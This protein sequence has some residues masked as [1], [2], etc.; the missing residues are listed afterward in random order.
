M[1][2]A[3]KVTIADDQGVVEEQ[4]TID[5]DDY[6]LEST[7]HRESLGSTFVHHIVNIRTRQALRFAS[8]A[9]L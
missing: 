4:F 5:P 8:E 1:F 7:L 6:N 9:G 3:L 2:T